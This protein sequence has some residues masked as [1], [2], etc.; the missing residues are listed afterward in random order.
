MIQPGLERIGQ[1]LKNVQFPWKAI[2]V[3]GT[4]GKG[5]VCHYASTL[6]TRRKLRCGKFTSPHLV[7][8]WDCISINEKPVDEILFRKIE[9]HYTQLSLK[10]N[11]SASPFE[12]LTATAFHIFNEEKVDVGVVEVGMGGKLDST[13]ILQNQAVSVISK[14]AR[15]HQGFL[16]N[17]LEEIALHKA[18]I[19]RPNV[20]Y[21]VN[22][23]NENNVKNVIREYAQEIGA[24]PL[25]NVDSPELQKALYSKQN[26]YRFSEPLLPFQRDN[27]VLALVAAKQTVESMGLEFTNFSIGKI[28]WNARHHTN[29]GRLERVKVPPI[30]GE[31]DKEPSRNKGRPVLV[32]GAHNPDAARALNDYLHQKERHRRISGVTGP[33]RHGWPITWVLAMTEGKEARQ[34]LEAL[35]RPGD[36]VITTTF[37]PVDGM[38]W[39]K[40]MDPEKLLEVAKSKVPMLTGLAMPIDGALRA[41]CAAKYMTDEAHPIVLTGSL[42]LVGEFHRE[43]QTRSAKGWWFDPKFEDDRK[44][45]RAMHKE[46]R[47]RV[48]KLLSGPQPC[49]SDRVRSLE[50]KTNEGRTE[51]RENQKAEREKRRNIQ[52][53]IA[54]LDLELERLRAE[55]QHIVQTPLSKAENTIPSGITQRPTSYR[56]SG[57]NTRVL[58]YDPKRE[59]S[60]KSAKSSHSTGEKFASRKYGSKM[61]SPKD[62]LFKDLFAED[63]FGED[64]AQGRELTEAAVSAPTIRYTPSGTSTG[65]DPHPNSSESSNLFSSSGGLEGSKARSPRPTSSDNDYDDAPDPTGSPYKT[66]GSRG[67]GDQVGQKA[68]TRGN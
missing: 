25:L 54:A 13:N 51:G 39:V 27:A 35:L 60:D 55:E 8:R 44:M 9:K 33:P 22:K 49:S 28:L 46:E 42:Y 4:N 15:D 62:K 18:G 16:G 11:I 19:L 63:R 3:A 34:F 43:L 56:M 36:N 68:A 48:N 20:P 52:E 2:H 37:G 67:K 7:D 58:K 61:Q 24:G 41:L 59:R 10:E 1:L 47:H 40:P 23:A 29:P 31:P 50:N 65:S 53:Q 14:V 5:S 38:P 32:D 21:I 17:T 12:I 45:F 66:E 30:F 57:S 6:L 64:A 26:W